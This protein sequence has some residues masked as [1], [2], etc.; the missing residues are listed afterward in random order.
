MCNEI[1]EPNQT[2]ILKLFSSMNVI[3]C[4]VHSALLI[5]PTRTIIPHIFGTYQDWHV[6]LDNGMLTII[7]FRTDG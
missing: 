5:N 4:N 2:V 7:R 3:P 1:F 6:R